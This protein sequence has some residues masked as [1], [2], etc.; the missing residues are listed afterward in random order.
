MRVRVLSP[1]RAAFD[2]EASAVTLPAFDGEWGV[3]PRHAPLV[4]ALATGCLRVTRPD[5]SGAAF[6]V[7]GGFAQ[8]RD[9][10]LTVLTPECAGP[11]E[12]DAAAVDAELA[13]LHGGEAGKSREAC[14]QKAA[15][16]AWAKACRLALEGAPPGPQR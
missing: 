14:N 5:G 12:L 16:L 10:V 3:L 11:G 7:R 13:R 6:A 4:A 9:N 15:Q 2:G 8:V 1:A